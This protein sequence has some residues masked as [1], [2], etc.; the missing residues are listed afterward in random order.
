MSESVSVCPGFTADISVTMGRILMKLG[1]YVGTKVQLNV[2]KF[3]NDH[4]DV[5]FDFSFFRKETEFYGAAKR[6]NNYFVPRL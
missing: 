2:L 5:N 6:N 4:Y 1:A 3:H